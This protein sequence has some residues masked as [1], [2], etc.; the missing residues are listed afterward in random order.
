MIRKIAWKNIIRKPLNSALCICLLLFGVGIISLLLIIQNQMEQKFANDLRSIDLVMG[1]KGSPLQL[2]LSAVYH[3]DSPTGNIKLGDAREI[4]EGP[5]I[6]EAIPLAYG[7]SY[8]GYRI[9]GTTPSYIDKYEGKFADGKVFSNAMEANIGADIA[10]RMN[11][12]VGD[13]FTGTHGD[14]KGG[15][16]HDDHPYEVVGILE[17]THSVLDQLVLTNIE[18]VWQ[19]H[20]EH[21]HEAHLDTL[22]ATQLDFDHDHNHDHNHDHEHE[23]HVITADSME[24]TAV[25]LKCKTKMSMLTLP[26]IINE[27]TNMQAVLPALEIN[28]L[29]HMLGIGASTLKL[30]AAGIIL[31]AGFSVF[32]V[33]YNRLRERKHELALMRAVGY[34]PRDLFKLLLFE[35]IIMAF[36]GYVIGWLLSRLGLFIVNHQAQSDFNFQFKLGFIPEEFWLFCLTLLVGIIAAL[37]PAW[38]AMQMDV[39]ET[40]IKK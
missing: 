31:M 33:L 21:S 10:V 3:L 35:G 1:S 2:V 4:M 23:D 20:S 34:R 37:I 9:L 11:L 19:V 6:E 17:P 29:F 5:F 16:E 14:V 12:N 32:F 38:R 22:H 24:I 8:E 27:Q 7:D 18:S 28:H 36:F 26:R 15:H 25:L 30:I 40:L 39:S 13:S